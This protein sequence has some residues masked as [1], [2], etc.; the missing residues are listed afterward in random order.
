MNT[1]TVN[2]KPIPIEH[3]DTILGALARAGINIPTLCHIEGLPPTGACRIC[4]VE[5]E[6]TGALIPSCS[7]PAHSQ[8]SVLTHSPKVIS[9]R[10]TIV[11]LL[12]ANHPDDCLYCDRNL[13]CELQKLAEEL[14]VR[15]RRIRAERI[16]QFVDNSSPAI[17]RDPEKCI[18]CGKCVR[19]CEEIQGV[20]ALD[21][22]GRG[23]K[24][25]ISTAFDVSLNLSTCVACGQCVMACPTGALVE[26]SNIKE[27]I[28]AIQDP[29]MKVVIQHAPAVSVSLAEEFG[30]EAGTDVMGVMTTAL[31]QIGFD[32]VFDTS[33]SA[34][35][36]IMEEATELVQ[37]ITQGGTLPMITSCSPAWIKFAETFY[38]EIL[39]NISSCKSP[40]QMLGSMIK[41]FWAENAKIPEEKVFSVSVMPCTAKKFEIE[42]EEMVSKGTSDIDAV[43]TTREL[44]KLIRMY[45]IDISKLESTDCDLPFGERSTAGKL[46]GASGGVM[47][48]AIRTAYWM[49]TG[50]EL[51]NLVISELRN[52]QGY[53]E[54]SVKI[55]DLTVKAGVVSGLGNARVILDKIKEG[56]SDLQFLEIMS[57]PGGC[58]N[59]GGQPKSI[60]KEAVKKRMKA[61]YTIDSTEALNLSHRN[62]SVNDLYDKFLKNPGSHKAHELLHTTYHK[63]TDLI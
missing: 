63:R 49:I 42:R 60:D 38:P 57:C 44:A 17:M 35:L 37:R 23:S 61:L 2:S 30:L 59:G 39:P 5:D 52:E 50:E 53:R 12:L 8:M 18:L 56:I 26:R 58:I 11:E 25:R 55:N 46:F 45:S 22:S 4:V 29:E 31:K 40:Q 33:F 10:K 41:H 43:L 6:K 21:F 48:A 36:T 24:S 47:E 3:G 13:N 15:Q 1:M 51:E 14:G 7:F 19:T 16:Q 54:L 62:C 9:A 28:E 34:D 32:H 27:V 20:S